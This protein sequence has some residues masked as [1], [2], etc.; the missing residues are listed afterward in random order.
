MID[1]RLIVSHPKNPAINRGT[2]AAT[3][4]HGTARLKPPW[5]RDQP[6]ELAEHSRRLSALKLVIQAHSKTS[7]GWRWRLGWPKI[8]QEKGVKIMDDDPIIYQNTWHDPLDMYCRKS[9]RWFLVC[10]ILPG[11]CC[12]NTVA[13]GHRQCGQSLHIR[14]W[15]IRVRSR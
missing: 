14:Y 9:N 12:A 11:C 1:N 4:L 8:Q 15:M 7:I 6:E 10:Q 2:T 13:F 3:A 5:G